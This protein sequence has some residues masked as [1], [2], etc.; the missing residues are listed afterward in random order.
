MLNNKYFEVRR[1]RVK[2]QLR[3]KRLCVG[4]P[5]YSGRQFTPSGI[6]WARINRGHTRGRS[7]WFL[8]CLKLPS[9]VFDRETGFG[10]PFL[11]STFDSKYFTNEKIVLHS[12]V[13]LYYEKNPGSPRFELVDVA[14]LEG[15]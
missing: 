1:A 7:A 8:F 5:L 15:I 14:G 9:A 12:Q 10:R 2:Y 11:S 6:S 13:L 4:N 3:Y